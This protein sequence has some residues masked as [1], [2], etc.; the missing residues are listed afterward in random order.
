MQESIVGFTMMYILTNDMSRWNLAGTHFSSSLLTHFSNF[1]TKYLADTM[2]SKDVLLVQNCLSGIKVLLG[3]FSPVFPLYLCTYIVIY[4][5][6]QPN[7]VCVHQY[8]P[9]MYVRILLLIV[10]INLTLYVCISIPLVSVYVYCYLLSIS[11]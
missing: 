10:G 9:C 6:Y 7:I 5:R 11:T 3:L 8:S 2:Y 1:H 4:R